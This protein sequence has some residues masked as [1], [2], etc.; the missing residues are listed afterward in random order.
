V[1]LSRLIALCL[2]LLPAFGARAD[3][4]GPAQAQALQQQLKDWLGGLLGPT[5]KLPDMPWQ[6]T[7]EHDHYLVTLPI[8]GLDQTAGNSAMTA[9]LRPL[10]GGRWSIDDVKMPSAASLTVTIPDTGDVATGGPMK[11]AFTVGKQ[12]THAVLDPGLAT[13]STLHI[14]VG[15]LDLTTDNAKE[16]QEQH[17]DSYLVDSA[18]KPTPEGRLDLT[19]DATMQGWKSATR[20][21]GGAAIAI[22]AQTMHALGRVDGVN[23]DRVAALLAAS[24]ALFSALPDD[25]MQKGS[26]TELP[27]PARAQ[28]RLMI[29]S[30]QDMMGAVR[31]EETVD[32]LQVEAA[33]M[34]G[35]AMRHLTVGFGGEAPGGKLHVWFDIGID[36]LDTPSLPPRV[37]AYLPHH[38]EIRP[39]M[40]G[41]QTSDLTKL[42]LDATEDGDNKDRFAPDIAAL[43]THGGAE[44][45][46]E[47]LSFDLGPAKVDGT[48][49]VTVTSPGAW[50]GEAHLTA[51]GLDDLTTQARTN[52]DLQQALPVLIMLRGLAKPDGKSLVWDIASDGPSVTVNGIDLS[53][54]GGDKPKP[55]PGP[56]QKR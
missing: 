53:Q 10:D 19:M 22:A 41:I 54:L 49:H 42:A 21:N 2:L 26:K 52:P 4:I 28:L 16:H 33:G 56:P 51:T 15:N 8:A 12:D 31:L 7:G 38:I 6:I 39:S 5:V 50:H 37:A 34:G 55:K 44:L 18:L 11:V 40:S 47:T 43:L 27:A 1:R 9:S 20:I 45:G 17:I 3:D 14:D 23:R 25:V 30:L 46:I 13:P 48:G 35:L 29:A 36:G 32:G 24:S